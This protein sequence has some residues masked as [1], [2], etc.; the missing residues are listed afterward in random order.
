MTMLVTN[1]DRFQE[2]LRRAAD[3]IY[4]LRRKPRLSDAK[5]LEV[6]RGNYDVIAVLTKVAKGDAFML[7]IPPINSQPNLIDPEE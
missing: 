7:G 1:K 6:I 2:W 5:K 3:N 4:E